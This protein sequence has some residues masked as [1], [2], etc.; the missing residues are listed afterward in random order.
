MISK[1]MQEQIRDLV[2]GK[3]K[4]FH[5]QAVTTSTEGEFG[6]DYIAR[7][8]QGWEFV[9]GFDYKAD[10]EAEMARCEKTVADG[11]QYGGDDVE[12]RVVDTEHE[13]RDALIT[14][15]LGVAP[16][17]TVRLITDLDDQDLLDEV[18]GVD[19]PEACVHGHGDCA[20]FAGGPCANETYAARLAAKDKA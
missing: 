20:E 6:R 18:Y 10:A 16:G 7:G 14:E 19:R 4:Q 3:H 13:R 11:L 2:T 17:E 9:A 15:A 8:D 12:F 1:T 5:L